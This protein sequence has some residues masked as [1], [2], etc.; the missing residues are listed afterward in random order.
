MVVRRLREIAARNLRVFRERPVAE[1]SGA[2]GDLGT[3]LPLALSLAINGTISFTSTLVFS[4]V[5]NILTGVY[6]GI[7]L[8]VQPMK[9][10]AAVAIISS[11]TPGEIAA[12]G[13]FVAACILVLSLTGLLRR[14]TEAVPIPVVKGIQLGAGLSLIIAAGGTMTSSL[15]WISPSWADNLLWAIAAFIFLVVTNIYRNI[16][17]ALICFWLGVVFALILT[18]QHM[19]LPSLRLWIPGITLPLGEDWKIGVFRA[20]I[21]QLPLTTLNSVVAVTHL[22]KDLLPQ[23]QT[24]SAIAVGLSVAIM[25][26]TGCWFGAM[27]VCHGSGGLAAQYRFGA[28]SGSSVIFLGVLKVIIGLVFGETLIALLK[29]FPSALLGVMVIAAGLELASVGESLNTTDARDIGRTLSST[30]GDGASLSFSG[31][32]R[33]K[34]WTVMMVTMGMLIAFRNDAIGFAAGM[35]CHRSYELPRLLKRFSERRRQGRIRLPA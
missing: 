30:S 4:G 35:L 21:G 8:P 15:D 27:P 20:G 1:I 9:A 2:F 7:P 13:I 18:A 11:F 34:R 23:V 29:R 22:S 3:F 32:E 28:R 12:A 33:K 6:F 10:V 24:P 26:L 25:N 17:Y 19:E 14:L 31:D 16:P 5:F